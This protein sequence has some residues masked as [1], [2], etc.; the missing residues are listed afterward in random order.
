MGEQVTFSVLIPVFNQVGKMDKCIEALKAQTFKD[1]EAII[2]DDGSTDDSYAMLLEYQKKDNR[3]K[4]IRHEKNKSLLEARFTAMKEAKGKYIFFLD[5]DDWISNDCFE[6]LNR[7]FAEHDEDVI[8]FGFEVSPGGRK[9]LPTAT[10]DLLTE[11]YKGVIPPAIWKNC[12]RRS[13]VDRALKGAEPF[14][15]NMGEDTYMSSILLSNAKGF[16]KTDD[17]LYFYNTGGMSTEKSAFSMDK[18]LKGLK[19]VEESGNH[20]VAYIRKNAPEYLTGAQEAASR[21]IRFIIK[22]YLMDEDDWNAIFEI[23]EYFKENGYDDAFQFG[24]NRVLEANVKRRMGIEIPPYY[25]G[26]EIR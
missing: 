26:F 8:C 14:Y 6:V 12:Y 19:S 17:I 4:V 23:L 9:I 18:M 16:Y 7:L 10:D 13:V 15:C 11:V 25:F 5:S 2:V 3:I 20:L 24:V 22:Q 21:M 1:F